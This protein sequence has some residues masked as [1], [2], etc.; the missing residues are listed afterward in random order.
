MKKTDTGKRLV[1]RVTALF[2]GLILG[3]SA[4]IGPEAAFRVSASSADDYYDWDY[5]YEDT[6]PDVSN[7]KA[8][9]KSKYA[10][11]YSDYGQTYTEISL[12]INGVNGQISA[13]DVYFEYPDSGSWYSYD[14]YFDD[15]TVS[16]QNVLKFK[17]YGDDSGTYK[18]PVILR[19]K[20]DKEKKVATLTIACYKLSMPD[21]TIIVKGKSKKLTVKANGKKR[22]IKIK[23]SSSNKKVATVTS[24]GKVKGKKVG[25]A[26]IYAKIGKDIKLGCAVAVTTKKKLKA[27]NRA[28]KI[29]ATCKYSQAK[30]MSSKYYDCSS[31]VWKAYKAAGIY[32]GSRS[33]APTAAAEAKYFSRKGKLKK[34]KEKDYQKMK[35]QV[36]DICFRSGKKN[37]RFKNI[38]HAEMVTGI[39]YSPYGCSYSGAYW[40]IGDRGSGAW[41]ARP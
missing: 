11:Y 19:G 12:K 30:R 29:V 21:G 26:I 18:V 38:Y 7:A 20:D 5:Y 32:I 35:Y 36:G 10:V 2:L 22:S 15:V 31:L 33:Y 17:A 34:F 14:V 1:S 9:P 4:F 8:A 41:M 6:R 24:S 16:S 13:D 39:H 27:V 25:N 37:G 28:K 3:I 40:G 23:W